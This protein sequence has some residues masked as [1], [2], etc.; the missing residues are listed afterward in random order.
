LGGEAIILS[1][2]LKLGQPIAIT[3]GIHSRRIISLSAGHVNWGI[4]VSASLALCGS[5]DRSPPL[6]EKYGSENKES[7][8]SHSTDDAADDGACIGTR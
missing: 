5:I 1:T 6:E 2:A 8:G 4:T 7:N 3:P